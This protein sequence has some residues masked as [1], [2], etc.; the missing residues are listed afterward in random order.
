MNEREA[1]LS[2]ARRAS[3]ILDEF[4]AKKRVS[5]GYTRVD[6]ELIASA[7]DVVV[8]YR[9]LD[10]LLGGF[11]REDGAPGIIVNWDRPRGLVHM[12]CA[13]E[14]GH[15]ALGHESTSDVTVDVGRNAA[16]VEQQA[17]QFAYAL[18]AP[19]WLVAA[20]MRQK[21]WSRSHLRRPAIV[22]QLSL[23]LGISYKA[24]VWSLVRLGHLAIADANQ[25]VNTQPI[26]LKRE[27]LDG[28][29]PNES[30]KDVWLLNSSDRDR[31]LEPAMGDQF[32]F[33]L[34]NHAGSG[35]L[36]SIDEVQSEGFTLQPFVR[37]ARQE[38]KTPNRPV[39]VG[40]DGSP[41]RYELM[42]EAASVESTAEDNEETRSELV[43]KRHS[44][45]VR[46]ST[47]WRSASNTTDAFSLAA[48]FKVLK[49]GFPQ[50][51]RERRLAE[52]RSDR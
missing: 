2:A 25:I 16:I 33:E 10:L 50:P 30:K 29:S 32:I 1:L 19:A 27:A 46:E 23:R 6:A 21:S 22:Y 15:F 28:R 45:A 39:V 9:K 43:S 11:L 52:S 36:W 41:M 26:S 18:L 20:T 4:E 14:L 8:L 42:A 5:E 3:E 35:H 40:G 12:T 17:N 7:S 31:I 49:T 38:G 34:P 13:H 37:D 51:E 47:P 48:E 24:M 44:L